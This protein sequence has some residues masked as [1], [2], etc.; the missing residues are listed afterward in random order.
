MNTFIWSLKLLLYHIKNALII[1]ML[2]VPYII[3]LSFA[4][5]LIQI[6][7]RVSC[8]VCNKLCKFL[9]DSK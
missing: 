2:M 7:Y 6:V 3:M 4:L 8:C 5:I 9:E 1:G